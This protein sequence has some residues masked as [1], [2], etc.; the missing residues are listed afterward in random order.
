M[1]KGRGFQPP[2]P[3][4]ASPNSPQEELQ[5]LKEQSSQLKEKLDGVMQRIEALEQKK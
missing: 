2:S 4:P 3:I 1:G 5:S